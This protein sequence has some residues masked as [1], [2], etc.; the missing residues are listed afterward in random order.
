MNIL[1]IVGGIGSGKSSV[2]QLLAQHGAVRLDADR[3]GH[4]VLRQTVVKKAVRERF[5]SAVFDATGEIDRK[6]MAA[7]VF[8]PTEQAADDLAFLNDLTHPRI[9]EECRKILVE[10]EHQGVNR[11]VLDAPLLLESRWN[12][13]TTEVIFVDAPE[14]IRWKRCE[15]RG[16]SRAEFLAREASQWSV[17]KKRQH[18]EYVLPNAGTF[19]D[20]E[21]EV[22]KFLDSSTSS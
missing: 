20:L 15:Q 5:G 7:I 17:E 10:L 9:T 12:E 4:D 18:A 3:I 19:T 8:A 13:F 16:W 14:S 1:G 6:K 2:A 22:Q 21:K 11:V